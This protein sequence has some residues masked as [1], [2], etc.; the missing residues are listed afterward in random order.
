M[1]LLYGKLM[2]TIIS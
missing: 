2:L 1:L